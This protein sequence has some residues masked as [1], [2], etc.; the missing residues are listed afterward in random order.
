MRK[1]KLK[2]SED[3]DSVAYV[4]LKN[5]PTDNEIAKVKTIKRLCDLM[6]YNGP[7]IIFDFDEN[8]EL[9]GIEIIGQIQFN[10]SPS[11]AGM[12]IPAVVNCF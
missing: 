9:I 7:D 1:I 2:V 4:S 11:S 10:S 8:D 12:L 6:N 3:D 5:H